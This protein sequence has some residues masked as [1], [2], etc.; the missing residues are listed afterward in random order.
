MGIKDGVWLMVFGMLLGGMIGLV[1]GSGI[2]GIDYQE[3]VSD[4]EADLPRKEHCILVAVP[5]KVE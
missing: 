4:C 5:E 1:A 3:L 2:S